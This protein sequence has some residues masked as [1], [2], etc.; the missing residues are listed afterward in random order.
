MVNGDNA[1]KKSM[2]KD[3]IVIR[4]W[5]EKSSTAVFLEFYLHDEYVSLWYKFSKYKSNFKITQKQNHIKSMLPYLEA[6]RM[7][8]LVKQENKNK[9]PGVLLSW[10]QIIVSLE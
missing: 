9:W 3:V 4:S 7:Y 10:I 6:E 1:K 2:I 8:F 5:H